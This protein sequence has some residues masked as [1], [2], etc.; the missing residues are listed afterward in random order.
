MIPP[1]L[2]KQVLESSHD[3]PL[4][5]HF[6]ADRTYS[7]ISKNYFWPRARDDFDNWVQSC[8]TCNE[9]NAPKQGYVKRPLRP[10]VT[11]RRFE[12]VCYDLA[13]PFMPK[14][15]RGMTYALIIVDHFSRWPEIAALPDSKAPTVAQAIFDNWVCRYGVPERLHSD[16]AKNVNGE[17]MQQLSVLFL[18][19]EGDG[20]SEAVV[21]LIKSAISKH[22]DKY[23]SNWDLYLQSAAYAIRSNMNCSTGI[24]PAELLVG[25]KLRHPSDVTFDDAGLR[26]PLNVRQARQFAGTLKNRLNDST[27]IVNETLQQSRDQMK[28]AYDKHTTKHDFKVGD[29][30]MIWDPPNQKGVSR[31]FQPKWSGVWRITR[32]I[33]DTNCRLEND[34]G[35]EKFVHL[36]IVKKVQARKPDLIDHDDGQANAA[37]P[38]VVLQPSSRVTEYV[39][40][41][42]FEPYDGGVDGQEEEEEYVPAHPIDNAYVDIDESNI[43]EQRLRR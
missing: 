25:G 37:P 14:T 32:I 36:N 21:K 18:H 30:V 11:E 40:P 41:A 4:S 43:M 26:P 12:L 33:G 10:I 20:L 42:I 38:S 31:S 16:G 27:K 19:P 35:N 24:T 1:S 2:R 9:Y 34:C 17:V 28:R 15:K 6:G 8:T 7:K 22:V 39:D 5:G 29:S 23:G 13:G 3:H